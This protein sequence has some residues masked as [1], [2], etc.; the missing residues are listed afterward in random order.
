MRR[1]LLIGILLISGAFLELNAQYHFSGYV[2]EDM[3][4]GEVYLS[5]VED[6]RK[7]SGVYHEQIIATT[8]P[9]SSG[10]FSFSGNNLPAENRLYRI[11]VDTCP[12]DELE[13][14]HITGHCSNS[15]EILFVAN[16]TIQLSLP[17]TFEDE[18]F[19]KVISD[20]ERSNAIIKID[21]LKND[22]RFSFSTYR[23]ETN[24]KLNTKKWFSILQQYGEQ[25]NE[26]L[27]EL[28]VFSFLSDRSSILHS[29]YL[30]DL[31]VNPWYDGLLERLK[32]KYPE[33]S[34]LEQY[35][36]ELRADQY[37][38][39]SVGEKILPAWVYGLAGL[40]LFSLVF[41]FYF[42]RRW[43][44]V[45][46]AIPNANELLSNQEQKVLALILADKTNKEIASEMFVSVSTVKTHINN[47]YKKL[48]VTSREE[49][50]SMYSS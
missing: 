44:K 10:Y 29:Y 17:T 32:A 34:Y 6:Y 27:A 38:V 3:M 49:V 47:L 45:V 30:E 36:A 46:N 28:Y 15:E 18:M 24:R 26:P 2:A 35:E 22:M 39:H 16:N 9:D 8:A 12:K 21:S 4:D 31:K 40:C 41:N 43:K 5:L 1:L 25:L 7:V 50:K 13:L 37:L 42:F 19:C 33:S 48:N 14:A 20:E 11:H 23:S